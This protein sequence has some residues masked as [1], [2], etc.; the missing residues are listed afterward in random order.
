MNKLPSCESCPRFHRN[1][2]PPKI[3]DGA[4]LF[5]VGEAPGAVENEKGEP[6]VGP[7]GNVLSQILSKAGLSREAVS[8]GNTV[9]C[10]VEGNP[11]P[12]PAEIAHCAP[13]LE[14]A[15]KSSG[16]TLV[17]ALGGVA[18]TRFFGEQYESITAW[19]GSLMETTGLPIVVG[20]AKVPSDVLVK[21]GPNK[22]KPKM[23]KAPLKIESTER[24]WVLASLHPAE[25]MYSGFK[26]FP[27]VCRDLVRAKNFATSGLIEVAGLLERTATHERVGFVLTH[28]DEICLDLETR[29]DASG[30]DAITVIG[31][32][33]SHSAALSA[34]VDHKTIDMLTAWMADPKH[35]LVGHNIGYDI[36]VLRGYGVPQPA[37]KLWDTQHAAH[38]ERSDMLKALDEVA[39]RQPAYL[40][41]NWKEEFETGILPDIITYNLRDACWPLAIKERQLAS[42]TKTGQLA[43]F[44]N[45]LMRVLPIL[46]DMEMDGVQIDQEIFEQLKVK[47]V[48]ALH[49]L[50]Q[51]W[52][53]TTGGVNHRSNPQ[54]K[55]YFSQLLPV[56]QLAS[57]DRD[58]LRELGLEFPLCEPLQILIKLRH[59]DKIL[60]TYLSVKLDAKGRLH[61]QYNLSGT[62]TGRLSS[63][64]RNGINFQN[65]PRSNRCPVDVPT[66]QC[67]N[68]RK[69]FIADPNDE[70]IIIGDWSQ[71]EFRVS[72]LLA[73]DRK[74]IAQYKDPRF[75]IH[76]EVASALKVD[77]ELAKRGVH[78]ANY[79]MGAARLAKE[80]KIDRKVAERFIIQFR[81]LYPA[82]AVHRARL[83]RQAAQQGWLSTPFTRRNYFLIGRDGKVDPPKVLA[84]QPQSSVG[85]MMLI[86]LIRLQQAGLKLRWSVHDEAGISSKNSDADATVLKQVM[87]SGYEQLGG[88]GCPTEIGGGPSWAAAKGK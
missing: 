63:G 18:L 43:H 53:A 39:S 22:G 28:A 70:G 31:I 79:G 45:V 48:G 3:V 35:T 11:K 50:E 54:L 30:R 27:I 82:L 87:E 17:V 12:T 8:I 23:I 61:P 58:A 57:L 36:R 6:F 74:L 85:D 32:G 10:Y 81:M 55:A 60:N 16:A 88:W 2:V 59:V 41:H 49:K 15:I 5:I 78:G 72:A 69:M 42:L 47:Q 75:S 51:S 71:I 33:L 9:A 83:V 52:D 44:E 73:N 21:S 14:Q 37:A 65:I 19:R 64:G 80:L 40:Y 86:A 24:R 67:A 1:L 34:P 38:F 68:L 20:V 13:M 84:F 26:D 25:L 66:C 56:K 46:I 29:E 76:R 77:Y 4:P 62:S 7:A